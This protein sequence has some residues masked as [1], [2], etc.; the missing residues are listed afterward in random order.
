[1]PEREHPRGRRGAEE[2]ADLALR[3]HGRD[4]RAD[5]AGPVRPDNPVPVPAEVEESLHPADLAELRS[6][7]RVLAALDGPA[8]ELADPPA[9]LWDRIAAETVV[10]PSEAASSVR[11]IGSAPSAVRARWWPL[12]AA[13]AVGLVVGGVA[14]GAALSGDGPWRGGS[15]EAGGPAA[16]SPAPGGTPAPTTSSSGGTSAAPTGDPA[17]TADVIGTAVMASPTTA[18]S[19]ARAEMTRDGDGGMRLAVHV[20]QVPAPEDGYLEVWVRD[21]AASRMIS[22]GTVTR[23]DAVL[24]VPDGVD[25]A[26]YPVV[27]VSHEH[28]DGDPTHSTT[29]LWVGEMQRVT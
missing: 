11:P 15:P 19:S 17:P 21:E 5:D 4:V 23:Q 8:P 25:L 13:A 24:T 2:I 14:V 26:A 22:L 3:L 27:D 16:T 29:S 7:L 10:E 1:M 28:F 9:E 20:P 18:G 6:T 12:A